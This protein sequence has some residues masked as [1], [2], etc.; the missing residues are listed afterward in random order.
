MVDYSRK[1]NDCKDFDSVF[2]VVKHTAESVIHRH[3]AGLTL[4]LARLP[5]HT[6]AYFA[7]TNLIVLNQ[8]L[9]EVV[10]ARAKD[11]GEVNAFVYHVLLHEYLHSLGFYNERKVRQLVKYISETVLA[12]NPRVLK[13]ARGDIWLIYPE[14]RTMTSYAEANKF[15]VVRD[16]DKSSTPYY[17]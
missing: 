11:I 13:L 16:F 1:L 14:L 10:K 9:L 4:S 2:E 8:S 12:Q 17:G 3:R 15:E 7:G 5:L 6:G